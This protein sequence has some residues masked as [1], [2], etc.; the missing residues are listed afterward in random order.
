MK[1]M[2]QP[3]TV[4]KKSKKQISWKW[5]KEKKILAMQIISK[6]E[7]GCYTNIRQ[8]ASRTKLLQ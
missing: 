8:I 2:M 3:Y 6:G 7:Q 5:K 1:K 4:Y